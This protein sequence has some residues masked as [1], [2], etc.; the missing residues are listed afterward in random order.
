MMARATRR[1]STAALMMPPAYPAPS[2]QGYRPASWVH[3]KF[4]SRFSRTGLLVRVSRPGQDRFRRGITRNFA[5]VGAQARPQRFGQLPAAAVRQICRSNAAVVG[6]LHASNVQLAAPFQKALDVLCRGGILSCTAPSGVGSGFQLPLE[7]DGPA[8][9]V[10]KILCRPR[11]PPRPRWHFCHCG[12][13]SSCR[14]SLHGLPRWPM[15]PPA[16]RGTCRR[17]KRTAP[18]HAG[19]ADTRPRQAGCPAAS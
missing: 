17:C 7:R 5:L 3:S 13:G 2:P 4:S 8:R 6:R 19:R 14:W 9:I 16:R 12:R 15:P 1:P 18:P 10:C 11:S